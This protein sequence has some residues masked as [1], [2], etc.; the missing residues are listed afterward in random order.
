MDS[1]WGKVVG[2]MAKKRGEV[3]DRK[4]PNAPRVAG[5]DIAARHFFENADPELIKAALIWNTEYD[6]KFH[7]LSAAL[8]DPR[9]LKT[10]LTK[11]SRECGVSL[12]ELVEKYHDVTIAIAHL[13]AQE[14]LPE[15]VTENAID[16]LP[17]TDVCPVCVGEK[18]VDSP[19]RIKKNGKPYRIRCMKCIGIGTVRVAGM[20]DAKKLIYEQTGLISK[21]GGGVAINQQINVGVPSLSDSIRTREKVLGEVIENENQ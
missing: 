19:T 4:R 18:M 16:A 2:V 13:R 12:V 9:N 7:K 8:S 1:P 3:L 15:I 21:G 6:S 14:K 10:N 20:I 17:T 11:L 5:A